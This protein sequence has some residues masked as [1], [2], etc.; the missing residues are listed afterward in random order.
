MGATLDA[1]HRLQEIELQIAEIQRG[2][3][4]KVRA[5]DREQRRID[6]TE[7]Q[8][9]QQRADLRQTQMEA[10]R[11]DVDVKAHQAEIDK[12]RHTLNVSKNNKEYSAVLT[13]LNTVKADNSKSE[14]RVLE[15]LGQIDTKKKAI[16]ASEQERDKE[17]A[18][19]KGFEE[20]VEAAK[21]AS[22]DRMD[23]LQKLRREAAS[24]V[25]TQALE[26]FNR[27]AKKN[28]GEAMALVIRTNPK[29]EEY[30]CQG[31]NM[32]VTLQQ[33][34]MLMSRDEAVTCQVCGRIL[35]LETRGRAV[36]R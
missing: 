17:V 19:L 21:A 12:L 25:P 18:K 1:L 6:E 10:D 14:D 26:F 8:I 29:R 16:A 31:C 15:L 23:E 11:L 24:G 20:A 22:K 34:N 28:D 13:Q 33:V 36:T 2:I 9:Q 30:A 7:A 3:D 35:Y 4:S 5:R 27:L 32:S